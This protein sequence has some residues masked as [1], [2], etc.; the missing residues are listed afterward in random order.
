MKIEEIF[1]SCKFLNAIKKLD[2]ITLYTTVFE[3][4]KVLIDVNV[5]ITEEAKN[6]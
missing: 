1:S 2:D 3:K 6:A 5:S 4:V